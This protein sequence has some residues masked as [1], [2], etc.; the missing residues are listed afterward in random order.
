M[1]LC[2]SRIGLA[3]VGRLDTNKDP[4]AVLQG[5][6]LALGW[7]PQA[8]LYMAYS[9]DKLLPEVQAYIA[10]RPTLSCLVA[11]TAACVNA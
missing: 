5:F 8:T 10:K 11:W 7:L 2:R 6:E 4:L 9:E 3:R 1:D